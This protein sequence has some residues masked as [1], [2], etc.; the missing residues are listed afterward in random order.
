MQINARGLH[1]FPRELSCRGVWVWGA[2]GAGSHP[3]WQTRHWL[4]LGQLEWGA[5][6]GVGIASSVPG[7]TQCC[8][9]S[10]GVDVCD[11]L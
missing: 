7:E 6:L 10:A 4:G 5:R 1:T 9:S 11:G 2:M 3:P 8:S